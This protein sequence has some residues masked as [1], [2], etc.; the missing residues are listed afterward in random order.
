MRTSAPP[1]TAMSLMMQ[2]LPSACICGLIWCMVQCGFCTCLTCETQ[3]RAAAGCQCWV[4]IHNFIIIILVIII[5]CH[6]PTKAWKPS[7][8]ASVRVRPALPAG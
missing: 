2:I 1:D 4:H 6:I 5:T 3:E 7:Q 8:G